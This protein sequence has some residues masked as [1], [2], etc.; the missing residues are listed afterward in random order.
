MKLSALVYF[1]LPDSY[2]SL[3]PSEAVQNLEEAGFDDL[4]H[5]LAEWGCGPD[6]T[7]LAYIVDNTGSLHY[8]EFGKDLT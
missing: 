4:T 7:H 1:K 3:T 8:V 5:C 2:S 6:A